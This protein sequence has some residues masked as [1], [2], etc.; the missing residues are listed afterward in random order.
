MHLQLASKPLPIAQKLLTFQR[1]RST[2]PETVEHSI[3]PCLS[4]CK[5]RVLFISTWLHKCRKLLEHSLLLGDGS[6]QGGDIIR[7]CSVGLLIIVVVILFIV[8]IIILLIIIVS[9][10]GICFLGRISLLTI[11]FGCIALFLLALVL[12]F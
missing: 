12:D 6:T 4:I 11:L 9:L 1:P 2:L 7:A 5:S 8:V 10:F 3:G